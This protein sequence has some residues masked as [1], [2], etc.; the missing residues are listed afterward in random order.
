MLPSTWR[1]ETRSAR[2]S[3]RSRRS[4]SSQ[5]SPSLPGCSSRGHASGTAS[6][7]SRAFSTQMRF[8]DLDAVTVDGYGT[9]LTLT[10]PVGGLRTALARHGVERVDGEVAAAFASEAA[11]YRPRAHL[12]RDAT[13]LAR[14]R[15]ECTAV[16]LA[17]L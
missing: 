10:G 15:V 5:T 12:G 4:A 1:R 2:S 8:A 11:Y 16:F 3:R 17:A 7:Q 13:S 9:L 6:S 14:L